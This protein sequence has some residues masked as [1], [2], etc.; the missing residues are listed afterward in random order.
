MSRVSFYIAAVTIAFGT[1]A[2]GQCTYKVVDSSGYQVIAAEAQY[3]AQTSVPYQFN[4]STQNGCSWGATTPTSWLHIT[5]GSQGVGPGPVSFTA[6]QNSVQTSRVGSLLVAGQVVTVTQNALLGPSGIIYEFSISKVSGAQGSFCTTSGGA[7]N[8]PPVSTVFQPSDPEAYL[9][10]VMQGLNTGDQLTSRYYAPDGS[11]YAAAGAIYPIPIGSGGFFIECDSDASGL[12]IF[13]APPANMG[14]NWKVQ[15]YLN[16]TLILEVPFT[17]NAPNT[18]TYTLSGNT[19]S[20]NGSGGTGSIT[21]TALQGCAWSATTTATWIHIGSTGLSGVGSGAVPYTVDANTGAARS[22]AI[23]IAGQSF[24]ITEAAAGP[25][26]PSILQGGIAEPWTG[27][28]GLAPGAW[29]SIYG[30]NLANTTQTWSPAAGQPLLTSLAGV[31]VTIDGQPAVPSSVSPTQ[32]NVL[33]PSA[34]RLGPVQMVV[35][36]NGSL[37]SGYS[38]TSN[39][40]LPAIYARAAPGISPPKYYVTAV[41]PVT[42]QIVGNFSADP[43]VQHAPRAGETIDLYGLGLGPAS[44]FPTGT[45][46][47]GAFPLNSSVTVT[48]GGQTLVPLFAGLVGPGLYQV[49]ITIPLS[50]TLGDQPV[51]LSVGGAA[52]S[53]QNVFLSI[54]Q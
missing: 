26:G 38:I 54:G 29:V 28:A 9:Y 50:T 27:S 18:C 46:F 21:V 24:T 2:F 34:V 22:G 23:T 31:S 48:L 19:N 40:F 39:T 37:S 36:N 33:V 41:D 32:I 45:A 17:I 52:Q 47:T 14:G 10:F 51:Q 20:F 12:K 30:N 7:P 53:P 4:V 49:R 15:L 1:V 43:S 3:T 11:L 16:N 44:Q 35:N 6:D 8:V 42:G 13:G 5:S 25:P